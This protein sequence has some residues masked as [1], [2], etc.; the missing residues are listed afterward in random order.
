MGNFALAQ[1]LSPGKT[2]HRPFIRKILNGLRIFPRLARWY[3]T[4]STQ[5]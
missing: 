1:S 5:K 4:C 2:T 3:P